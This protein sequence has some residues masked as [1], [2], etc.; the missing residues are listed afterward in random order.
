M[1]VLN[2]LTYEDLQFTPADGKRY[3]L[4]EGELFVSAA[5]IPLHQRTVI[6]LS[7]PLSVHVRARRLG[8]I[9]IAPCD[10]V[11]APSTVLEPDIFFVSAARSHV[12]GGEVF[13]GP[14]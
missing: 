10:I 12:V 11:F 1:S 3:E 5:P 8:E 7:A 2:Q 13:N 9:F 14:A 6:R 4:V